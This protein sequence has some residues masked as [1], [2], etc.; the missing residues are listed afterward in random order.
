[1]EHKNLLTIGYEGLKIDEF[2]VRLK[3]FN[4]TRLIDVREIPI[5]RKSGF[6]KTALRERLE[7]ESIEYVHVKSLGSPAAIR[8]Q[9]KKD[10]D[11]GYCFEEYSRYL[12]KNVDALEVFHQ[13]LDD[14]VNCLMCFER[15]P[16]KC[17]RSVV[18]N[19][20]IENNGNGLTIKHI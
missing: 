15:S 4:V 3:R 20:I 19:K 13:F 8:E 16:E 7:K 6:S 12:T 14:G 5:S 2:I 17:H 11:Y 18:A 10:G 9:L 1:M